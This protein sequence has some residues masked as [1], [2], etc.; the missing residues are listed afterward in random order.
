MVEV[1]VSDYIADFLLNRGVDLVFTI[2][3]AGNIRMIE[4]INRFG[5]EYICTHHEQAAVM[6]AI[7]RFR[8]TG[9]P[10]VCFFTGGP[11]AANTLT[12]V[13][14]AFLDSIP[15]IIIAGQ[16][17]MEYLSGND[18]LRGIGVQG[19]KMVEIMKSVTKKSTLLQTSSDI[20]R[21][22]EQSFYLA[23]EG[24]PGPVWVEIPQDLQW[25][26]VEPS[27][28]ESC[29]VNTESQL[30]LESISNAV[31]K[32][33]SLIECSKKPLIWVGHGV[34][35][36]KAEESFIKLAERLG[37]PILASWQGADIIEDNH[38]L[39]VGRAGI[40][41][42]RWANFALQ[43]CDLLICLGTRLAIPQ[44]GYDDKL[45]APKAKKIIVDIDPAEIE[46]YEFQVELPIVVNVKDFIDVFLEKVHDSQ[47]VNQDVIRFK[48]WL[49][50]CKDWRDR[51]PMSSPPADETALT[52]AGIN[53]YWFIE[54]LSRHLAERDI[55]VTDMGTSLTCTH[56]TIRI[57]KGQRLITSTGLGEMGFG[58]PAAIG[59]SLGDS[60]KNVVLIAGEGSLMMNLQELQTLKHHELPIKIFILNNNG[61]LT[62]KHTHN[63]LFESQGDAEA[64]GPSTGI[65]FPDFSKISEAFGLEYKRISYPSKIDEF[66]NQVLKTPQSIIAEVMMQEFQ[67]LIPKLS[68]KKRPDGSIYSPPLEDLYPF[69][70]PTSLAKELEFQVDESSLQSQEAHEEM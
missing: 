32:A 63:S 6:A 8:V 11:G 16:E 20:R 34:R 48:D 62:I 22:L 38:P 25:A 60:T 50:K 42:Q 28:L 67:E 57:K 27:K 5:I 7:A 36:A 41:G 46:K 61:Y 29:K 23:T 47:L 9:R 49:R 40:Y 43:T 15:C 19:L 56:A 4:S 45:F 64:T 55:I 39:F 59:A 58:L 14:D 26:K 37:I 10:A 52:I 54:T 18:S 53:S 12:G 17:K 44:R 68:L 70:N 1:T 30:N 65:S 69:L 2:T 66:I 13:A 31:T 3:G 51:F 24:R 21:V 35:L 33:I